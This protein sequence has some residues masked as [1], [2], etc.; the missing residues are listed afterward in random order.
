MRIVIHTS[1]TLG[2]Q[3]EH[4]KAMQAGLAR[5]GLLAKIVQNN[6]SEAC[7]IAICWGWKRGQRILP[8][9]PVLVMERGY[10]GDRFHWTSLG[11]NGLNGRADFRLPDEI[12]GR[13]W[14]RHFAHLMQDW[15]SGGR[16][17][18]VMG[19]VIGDAALGNV[20]F[21]HWIN[22]T[23]A[24]LRDRT[25]MEVVFRPH[26]L[27]G[28]FRVNAPIADGPLADVLAEA[29]AVV[30]WNSN[31]GVDAVLAGVPTVT[32]DQGSMAWPVTDHELT[33]T[34]QRHERQS[35]AERLAWCQWTL[36]EIAD[37]TAWEC[38]GIKQ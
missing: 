36:D 7:D 1:Q 6:D 10:V 38:V 32:M 21:V 16:S 30:T 35:W 15:R 17:V 24:Q 2:H 3:S 25:A 14:D 9:R 34:P 13:R 27:G 37:G 20:N 19:Q 8:G 31:S 11:W 23:I 33:A 4:A 26:P 18:V 28:R 12:D 5:H 29:A 22:D